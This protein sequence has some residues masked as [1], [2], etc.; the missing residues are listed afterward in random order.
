MDE[1]SG[2]ASALRSSCCTIILDE[3]DRFGALLV[4]VRLFLRWLW[5]SL[6]SVS[7]ANL[8]LREGCRR[9]LDVISSED[10]SADLSL[11]AWSL[12][13][14]SVGDLINNARSWTT[15]LRK[16][17]VLEHKT[18]T[19]MVPIESIP[20]MPTYPKEQRWVGS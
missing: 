4:F 12:E 11:W 8:S 13:G 2:S 17:P 20:K 15:S 16:D 9:M 19:R 5:A 1:A 7:F 10:F 18:Q 3:I 6:V 14:R